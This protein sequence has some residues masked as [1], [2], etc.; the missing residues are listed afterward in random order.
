MATEFSQPIHT[1]G[2]PL[3]DK[4]PHSF[5]A[6]TIK[7]EFKEEPSIDIDDSEY[8][9]VLDQVPSF[10]QYLINSNF[11]NS[12]YHHP[13]S[14]EFSIAP[15]LF[16][17]PSSSSLLSSD[18]L[19]LSSI[20]SSSSSTSLPSLAAASFSSPS[21]AAAAAPVRFVKVSL[22]TQGILYQQKGF[23]PYDDT[24]PFHFG[25]Q[26]ANAFDD[27]PATFITSSSPSSPPPLL[28]RP[29]SLSLACF[30]IKK[31]DTISSYL[32]NIDLDEN[33]R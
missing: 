10:D 32:E 1:N 18:S 15:T 13:N 17:S 16:H 30:D 29:Q 8:E 31:H 12:P 26:T 28:L 2:N 4:M 33:S 24:K 22:P 7:S 6:G 3:T 21:S 14:R 5:F 25:P 11:T 9:A 19:S 23:I 20:A 27:I